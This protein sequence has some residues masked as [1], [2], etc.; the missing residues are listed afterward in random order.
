MKNVINID[1]EDRLVK[2]GL[3]ATTRVL[4]LLGVKNISQASKA[5]NLDMDK[6]VDFVIPGLETGAK[7]NQEPPP[8]RD[9]VI[10]AL[11]FDVN[12]F[13]DCLAFFM[14]DN[15]P[16][17]KMFAGEKSDNSKEKETEGN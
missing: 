13:Y 3:T 1:G 6:W 17:H 14:E 4:G 10:A 5:A 7:I 15:T 16:K 9:Q 11:D 12:V 2:Y 8:T